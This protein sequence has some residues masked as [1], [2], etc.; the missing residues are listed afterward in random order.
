M[1]QMAKSW[2]PRGLP[3][4]KVVLKVNLAL[5]YDHNTYISISHPSYLPDEN[6]QR[7][8]SAGNKMVSL[9]KFPCPGHHD[10]ERAANLLG[11]RRI[12]YHHI[13]Y[14]II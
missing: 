12:L 9:G 8:T 10:L 14:K 4:L 13:G 11:K 1:M 2:R 6:R 7:K 5:H 3:P